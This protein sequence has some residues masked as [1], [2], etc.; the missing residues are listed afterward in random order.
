M[1]KLLIYLD[2]SGD[3]GWKFDLP[4]RR[5]GSSRYLTISALIVSEESAKLPARVMRKLYDK[6]NWPTDKE[7]KW[8]RM[9]PEERSE[10]SRLAA[11]LCA[12][13][14]GSIQYVS[15]TA[16][17][18]NVMAHIRQDPNKLY[19][20]MIGMLLLDHMARADQVI[21]LPDDRSIKVQSGNSLH[22]YLQTKLWMER[23]V[24]TELRTAPCD[25]SKNL[26]VQFADMLSGIAQGHYEDRNSA[27]LQTLARHFR[28]FLI[29]NR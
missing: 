17:K 9:T 7:K 20:Y 29:Y 21:F 1:T 14:A 5:G 27:P 10:F 6:F 12:S 13:N 15:I 3:L 28:P 18:E 8:A 16:K 2:E 22:D 26:C 23:E 11:K 4:Y 19:N 25:S 24:Q